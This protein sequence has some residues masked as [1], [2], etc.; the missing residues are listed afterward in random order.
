MKMSEFKVKIP[1]CSCYCLLERTEIDN[2][3]YMKKTDLLLFV[4]YD[5]GFVL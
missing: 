3:L 1:I 4:C 2:M 5:Y